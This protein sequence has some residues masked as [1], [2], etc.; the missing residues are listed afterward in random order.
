VNFDPLPRLSSRLLLAAAALLSCVMLASC[1][2]GGAT[3]VGEQNGAPQLLPAAATLYAG[4]PYTFQLVGGRKPYLLSSSEPVLLPV[5]PRVDAN[6]FQ[7]VANNP[8]VIDIGT[9][10]GQLPVRS[11]IITVRD[12]FGTSFSTPS[13]NGIQVAQNFM[14]GYGVVFTSTCDSEAQVCSGADAIVRLVA[15]TNGLLFQNRQVRFC[16]VRGNF[17]FVHPETPSNVPATQLD[18]YDTVTDHAGVAIARIRVPAD[19]G[20]QLATLRVIDIASG[21][22]V[23][24]VFTIDQG[25]I[26]GQLSVIPNDFTFT[27]PRTGVCGTGTADFVVFDGDPPYTAV[28]SNPNISVT[29]TTNN[30]NPARFSLSAFNPNVCLDNA[31]IVITDRANRRA[32][33]TVS[34]EEGSA[35]LPA[36]AVAP[37]TVSLND[38]CGFTT[39]V[40]AVGGVGPLSV[41]SSHPRVSATLSGNTVTITRLTPDPASPPGPSFYP[42][43][44]TVTVTDGATIETVTVSNVRQFCP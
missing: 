25:S 20:T 4:V 18:C 3:V 26:T 31:T 7:V 8:A 33:V 43:T 16:V 40:T 42:T 36:L 12:A 44:A 22:Y 11:V 9:Q 41:N 13:T 30:S 34:T 29:P 23:D 19:A 5:P 35:E 14:T 21:A 37:T 1:G 2:G 15:T 6:S 24:E 17:K 28:S 32:T 27:G 38:T 10:P 39:S